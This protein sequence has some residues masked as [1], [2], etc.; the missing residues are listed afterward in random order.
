MDS[1][2]QRQLLDKATNQISYNHKRNRHETTSF[3]SIN[4]GIVQRFVLW[5][6]RWKKTSGGILGK[7]HGDNEHKVIT[8]D[9]DLL[10]HEQMYSICIPEGMTSEDP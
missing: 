5:L 3:N 1:G 10:S 2:N 9:P 7:F 4:Y 6:R 8:F